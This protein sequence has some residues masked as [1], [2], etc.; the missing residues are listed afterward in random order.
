MKMKELTK[1]EEQIMHILWGLEKGFVKDVLEQFPEPRPAYNTVST[2]CRI[3]EKKGFLDYKAY[4][5]SHQYYPL[6][7]REIYTREY[8]NNF[9]DSYFGNSIAQLVSFFSKQNKVDIREAEGIIEL[10]NHI[11]EKNKDA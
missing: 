4:G 6:I 8:L 11:K 1:A 10:M 2:I 3:L 7:T 9:V 5:N